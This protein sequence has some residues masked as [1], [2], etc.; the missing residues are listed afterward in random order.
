MPLSWNEI[1]NRAH[2]FSKRWENEKSEDAEAKP[3]WVEFFNVFGIDRKRVASFEEPVKKLGDKQGYIDMFWKGM[4]LVEH[5]SRGKDLDKAYTQALDYFPGIK[6]R[7][8]PKHVLVSDFARFRLYDL[9]D[10]TQQ[11]F[12]LADLHKRIKHFAFI[13]GYRTQTITPQNP[14][15]IKAAERMG[16]LH[17][18]LKAADYE[19]HPLEVLLVRLLFCLFAEDT[20]I[21]Q[22]ASA[23]RAWIEERTA[24]DGSD[25]G[26]QLAQL[27]QVLNT[28]ENRRAKMLDEQ[29]AAFPYVNGKLFEEMLPIASFNHAMRE[30][31]L[32]CCALD[33][34]SISP[35]I[36]GAL[37]QS[38]MDAKARRN[39]GAHYTSEENI[40]K[41]IQP[42][43]LDALWEE[44]NRVKSNKN[45]L[46]EFHKKLRTLTFFDPACGCGN[47]LVI[48]YRELRKL[49]LEVLRT[50]HA[51]PG[52]RFLDIHQE[53]SVDVDQF[54]GI[55]IEE[56][57][58]QIA[59]VAMWLMD[60]QM[61]VR[62]SEEF[63]MYFARIPLKTSPHIVND[64]ALTLEWNDVLP[65]EKASYVFGNPPFIGKK[66]QST[67]QKADVA[68]L[69]AAIKGSG[70]LDYVAAWYV[71]AARYMQE[72][73]TSPFKGE[74][75]RGMGEI[76]TLTLP[77][78]HPNP[79]LEGEGRKVRA[80]FVSTNSITQGEQ[81]GVLW[82]WLLNQGMHIHFAHRT[83]Q[84]SNEARGMAAV[85]CVIIGFGAFDVEKK[86]IYEYE[87]I[88][89]DAHAVAATNINPYLVDAPDA[90]LSNRRQPISH[91]P[92]IV[93]GNMPNDGG[94]LLMTDAE[95]NELLLKEPA[96]EKF[97]RPF[98][99]AYE[100]INNEPR[101][102][103]WLL[104]VS[105]HELRQLPE[106]SL[107][108]HAVK[109]LREA[110]N[111]PATRELAAF[112][113]LFGE[114]RQPINRYLAIPK[115]SSERRNFIPIAFLDATC[116]A[117][118]E[119]FTIDSATLYHFGILTSTMHMAWVRY[120]CGRMK[121]DYRYSAGIV[122]NNYPWPDEP[123]DKQR[124][125][126][127]AAAQAVLDARAQF[128]QSSLADLY[129]P[130]TMPPALVKAHQAL[131]R[132][133]DACYR[134]ATFTS[135][136]Q[137]VEFLFERYQQLTSL[138]P[139]VKKT[140]RRKA[141]LSKI[142]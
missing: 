63:G 132:A 138:L 125:T 87:D 27:F 61:N 9:E 37:F 22:P 106:I 77:H 56:F 60:H 31:L 65:A 74:A 16:K 19:G 82:G 46:F 4:L 96:A 44:F 10:G 52:S 128:P 124:A 11:E 32:D 14:V 117:S 6:E 122:Y 49:E 21:F 123:S 25:L 40:L 72:K 140:T 135:D 130:L 26:P 68:P 67:A 136:A 133:V 5:K 101:W 121:S 23:F 42:L 92:E 91:I 78:P 34:S 131:D 129:D 118:T 137:R 51:G 8:L 103:L 90:H 55:E 33:W 35:A 116:I 80:A 114:I 12:K 7:D 139:T 1:R 3:F 13:A 85:H 47:F 112:P 20:G 142:G 97:I 48:A 79:P 95:K 111:R 105:P 28:P 134:K 30:A 120:T 84:W 113:T 2:E 81:A 41:L 54:Y 126:V 73:Y 36:F 109:Q 83:F 70:V 39:I 110:S 93:F 115:T 75:G 38:I 107:R 141:V 15:N 94:N 57:P 58:A 99:S 45:K 24:P 76:A 62:V 69:F 89:G 17:D 102:C 104:D 100:F 50:V 64:N 119:L 43:F 53:I 71:K 127:E 98:M 18:A 29:S 59:Q 88:R 108:V 86:I 66:E